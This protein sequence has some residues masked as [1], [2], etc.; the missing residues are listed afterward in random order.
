MYSYLYENNK[1]PTKKELYKAQWDSIKN[2]STS[3]INFLFKNKYRQYYDG[4]EIKEKDIKIKNNK[5]REILK[6]RLPQLTEKIKRSKYE[7]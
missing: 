3:N 1:I 6:K 5:V 4:N 7:I 2:K